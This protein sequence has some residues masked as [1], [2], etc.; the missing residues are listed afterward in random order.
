MKTN[1]CRREGRHVIICDI[2]GYETQPSSKHFVQCRINLDDFN[3]CFSLLSCYFG[4][5]M[6]RLFSFA[7]LVK[8]DG[9]NMKKKRF[10]AEEK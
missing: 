7:L 6:L 2:A 4:D 3:F 10:G 5:S 1:G 8:D 9:K